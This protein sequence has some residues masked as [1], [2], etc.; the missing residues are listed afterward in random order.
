MDYKKFGEKTVIRKLE[1]KD[2]TEVMNIWLSANID[3]H[4]FI[5][6]DY[7]R[8]QFDTVKSLIPQA[9]V[10]VSEKNG[11]VIGFIGSV[12]CYIAGIF[13][14]KSDRSSG[15]GTELLNIVKANKNILNLSVYAKNEPAI[16]FYKK[17]GFHI[18]AHSMDEETKE[19]ECTMRW[20]C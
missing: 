1:S 14:N 17:E 20:E 18:D 16:R 8:S 2:L 19:D 6:A 9:E 10:Y 13:V 11:R 15:V 5:S 3:A 4:S 7:W 12:D